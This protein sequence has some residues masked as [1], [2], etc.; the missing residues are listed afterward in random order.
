M[1]MRSIL[2]MI[3][4]VITCACA[5]R[6]EKIVLDHSG[7]PTALGTFSSLHV[8]SRG[9]FGVELR[10]A[11]TQEPGYQAVLQFGGG[12]FC[13]VQDHGNEP[14]FRVSNLIL[15]EAEFEGR[16]TRGNDRYLTFR[17][18]AA[19]GYDGAFEG[20][21]SKSSLSGEFTFASGRVLHVVLKRGRSYWDG[22][23]KTEPS[24]K[25]MQ[26]TKLRAA[27]VL[28]AEVPPCAPAGQTDGAPLRS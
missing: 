3:I 16:K 20:W 4:A 10:I 9:V 12:E 8:D 23:G 27:P 17:M 13:S 14:C 5:A 15:V 26:L 22:A 6:S 11:V 21:V 7:Q 25:R 2:T 1:G 19:S 24:N 28:H 18:P